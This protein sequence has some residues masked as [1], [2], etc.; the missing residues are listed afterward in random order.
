MC[1]D[2]RES[3]EGRESRRKDDARA[4]NNCLFVLVFLCKRVARLRERRRA[5][6]V[7][8][9][10]ERV[11][12]IGLPMPAVGPCRCRAGIISEGAN[13]NCALE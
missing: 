7:R 12:E 6:S 5:V 9:R 2:D 13:I 10:D 8:H 11:S 3:K 1:V 4:E